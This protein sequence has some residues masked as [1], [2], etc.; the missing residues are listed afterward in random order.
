MK[1][2]FKEWHE[3]IGMFLFMIAMVGALLFAQSHRN[4]SKQ[5]SSAADSCSTGKN[6]TL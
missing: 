3:P 1:K 6:S 2:F 4:E 5:K